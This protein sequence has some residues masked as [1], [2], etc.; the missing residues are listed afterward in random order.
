GD[1]RL[2]DG[3]D[4]SD[5]WSLGQG[6]FRADWLPA[7]G[8][9]L[10]LQGDFY[11][12]EADQPTPGKTSINGQNMLGRWTHPMAEN[13][14]M[15]LQAYWDR[16]W[17]RIPEVFSEELNTFDLDFQHRFPIGARNKFIWG[18]GYRLMMDRVG[19]SP[20]LAFLPA[21]RNL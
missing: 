12:G 10:T 9:T 3:R 5:D 6:G 20:L 11:G 14:D 2:P 15:T 17:R 8:E 1:T 16:T 7:H 19:N 21:E 13:S 18:A 4:A